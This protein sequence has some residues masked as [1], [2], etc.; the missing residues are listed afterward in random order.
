[1]VISSLLNVDS[2]AP[3]DACTYMGADSGAG[4]QLAMSLWYDLLPAACPGVTKTDFEEVRYSTKTGD[5]L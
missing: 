2:L 5:M 1:M 4:A 3:V